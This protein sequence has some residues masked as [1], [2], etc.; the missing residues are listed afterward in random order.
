MYFHCDLS[1]SFGAASPGRHR[2][3]GR[4]VYHLAEVEPLARAGVVEAMVLGIH[5]AWVDA[6]LPRR[7]LLQHVAAR[8][9]ELSHDLEVVAG[10]ARAVGVLAV[11]SGRVVLGLIARRLPDLDTLPIRLQFVGQ[12]HGNAGAH[13]LTHLRPAARDG[14]R[15]VVGNLDEEIGLD[16]A[17]VGLAARRR[18][19]GAG[20][21]V[22]PSTRAPVTPADFRK[23]RRLMFCTPSMIRPPARL[24]GPPRRSAGRCRSDRCCRPC[25]R[26]SLRRW[27]RGSR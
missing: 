2:D 6:P 4:C 27:G 18:N 23:V 20:G 25:R 1:L 19:D 21:D 13:A 10:A 24:C 7:R 12:D 15:S 16:R 3:V 14:H 11:L 5:L 9:A 26:R 8:G 17:A 22:A